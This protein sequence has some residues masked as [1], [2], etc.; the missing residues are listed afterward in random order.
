MEGYRVSSFSTEGS[1]WTAVL[2]S[3]VYARSCGRTNPTGQQL[4]PLNF[5]GGLKSAGIYLGR[6]FNK[7]ERLR[8]EAHA[9]LLPSKFFSGIN[10]ILK[11]YVIRLMLTSFSKKVVYACADF[12]QK[13]AKQRK[14]QF[15]RVRSILYI[16]I[17]WVSTCVKNR[18]S[19]VYV[20]REWRVCSADRLLLSRHLYT[21]DFFPTFA[22]RP[23]P[24]V[25]YSPRT[26]LPSNNRSRS[27]FL[28]ARLFLAHLSLGAS[29]GLR[30]K[31]VRHTTIAEHCEKGRSKK[32][33]Q[34]KVS[35]K[36]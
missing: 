11:W 29:G 36:I 28:P 8:W 32:K 27:V 35:K 34:Q 2:R 4:Q 26:L 31:F 14:D 21:Y 16:Y 13:E 10:S 30:V 15:S 18:K 19:Y 20:C 6:V 22:P 9:Q 24:L 1:K 25:N 33:K 12:T 3:G 23:D 17:E 7:V 5:F